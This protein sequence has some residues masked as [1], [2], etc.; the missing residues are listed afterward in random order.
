MFS[1]VIF[2]WPV[3]EIREDKKMKVNLVVVVGVNKHKMSPDTGCGS[4]KIS[5]M[6]VPIVIL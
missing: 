3:R 1:F 4:D 5:A 2:A 6:I